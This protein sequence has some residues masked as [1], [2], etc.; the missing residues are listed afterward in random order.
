MASMPPRTR[1]S[2]LV[3]VAMAVISLQPPYVHAESKIPEESL[4]LEALIDLPESDLAK[5]DIATLNLAAAEGLPGSEEIDRADMRDTIDAWARRVATVTANKAHFFKSHPDFYENSWAK[6]CSI[7]LVLTLQQDLR[8][9]YNFE[10]RTNPS[11]AKSKDQFLHGIVE[12][13]GGTCASLPVAFVAV[14]RRLGYPLKLAQG[15]S[16]YY[17][18][19]DDPATGERFNIEASGPGGLDFH[20][21]DHYR[22]MAREMGVGR[23][24][25]GNYFQSMSPREEL[26]S[27]LTTRADCL[28]ENGRWLEAHSTYQTAVELAPRNLFAVALL[29]GT[30]KTLQRM[31]AAQRAEAAFQR[32][33]RRRRTD[34]RLMIPGMPTVPTVHAFNTRRPRHGRPMTASQP[35]SHLTGTGMPHTRTQTNLDGT[36]WRLPTMQ[37]SLNETNRRNEQLM[38]YG[39]PGITRSNHGGMPVAPFPLTPNYGRRP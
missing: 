25:G 23:L 15:F 17:A 35:L 39:Q 34:P 28:R 36:R 6:Y 33:E 8:V 22:E 38:R 37:D 9:H 5:V 32:H 19:W 2:W 26:S 30:T 14:G 18:R 29:Q 16:H 21:D 31:H 1:T 27:F 3:A 10:Q 24:E 7:I 4:T 11:L 12:G 13:T 20:D